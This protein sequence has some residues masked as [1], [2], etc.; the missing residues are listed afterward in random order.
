MESV[1]ARI[2]RHIT[3][4]IARGEWAENAQLPSAAELAAEFEVSKNLVNR[5]YGGLVRDKL[6]LQVHGKGTFVASGSTRALDFK[7]RNVIHVLMHFEANPA[8]FPGWFHITEVLEGMSEEALAHELLL[9]TVFLNPSSA[10]KTLDL[11]A[12]KD[13]TLGCVDPFHDF[14]RLAVRMA[15]RKLPF[16]QHFWDEGTTDRVWDD[17]RPA[18][19]DAI[20]HLLAK[21]RRRVLFL[22]SGDTER[23]QIEALD[24]YRQAHE[25]AGVPLDPSLRVCD[26]NIWTEGGKIALASLRAGRTFDAVYACNDLTAMSVMQMFL[27]EGIKIPEDIALVGSDD[28]PGV[29]KWAVPLAS[30]RRERQVMGRAMV[31]ALL[32]RAE[33]PDMEKTAVAV[34]N[35]FVWRQS[36]G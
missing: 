27:S 7:K 4:R 19:R 22:D 17:H 18:V 23:L 9:S 16:V 34:P 24:G 12:A 29:D 10:D 28:M 35:R 8:M 30:V 31:K 14:P 1:T 20:A 25:E 3:E 33:R 21:G 6:L 15:R 26:P 5:V 32:A 2:V 11:L 13:N 36:A